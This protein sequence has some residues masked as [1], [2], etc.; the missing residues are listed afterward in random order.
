MD[1]VA[2]AKVQKKGPAMTNLAIQ[3]LKVEEPADLAAQEI[4]VRSLKMFSVTFLV[5]AVG[6]ASVLIEV[7]ILSTFWD[8]HWRRQ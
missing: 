2:T 6:V 7:L 1:E 4:L 8:Y 3:R 5:E